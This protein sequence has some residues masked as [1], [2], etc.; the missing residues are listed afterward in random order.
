MK[1]G[2]I[3]F[4]FIMG[5]I[6]ISIDACSNPFLQKN[7]NGGRNIGPGSGLADDPF[8]VRTVDDLLHVGNPEPDTTWAEWDMDKHYKQ[9]A[10]INL[11]GIPNW[12][13]IGSFTGS[14]DGNGRKIMNLTIAE[15]N[16]SNQGL[17]SNVGWPG[18]VK[19]LGLVDININITGDGE[20]IGGLAGNSTGTI[21]N[22][23]VSGSISGYDCV[24]GIVG[25]NYLKMGAP[26]SVIQ[27][28]YAVCEIFTS[29]I[30]GGIAGINYGIVQNCY[31]AGS[32]SADGVSADETDVGGIAGN[33][34]GTLWNCVALNKSVT[35]EVVDDPSIGRVAGHSN[36]LGVENNYAWEGMTLKI[37]SEDKDPLD[38]GLGGVDG[39]PLSVSDIKTKS[40]W[41]NSGNWKT[42]EGA[43]AWDFTNIWVWSNKN[44]P[45]LKNFPA[46][47]WPD[48][49]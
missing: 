43:E 1:P 33:N 8:L 19:N 38:G 9:I 25:R 15:Y 40:T 45:R 7:G 21:Q 3:L 42:G 2:K 18:V 31:A 14:Y 22:C 46:L 37:G 41:T 36:P 4:F 34:Y 44:M 27:N 30:G 28:C 16:K 49:L 35:S 5:I 12:T 47:P 29:S 26:L 20:H 32:V 17:F 23:Y 13:P 24:G 10:D 6:L 11:A 39:Q 48:Y